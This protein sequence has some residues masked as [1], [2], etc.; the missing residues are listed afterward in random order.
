V[1][2]FDSVY[3]AL[4]SIDGSFYSES[5]FVAPVGFRASLT[6]EGK[7]RF[8][9]SINIHAIT[10]M[11]SL[12]GMKRVQV[13]IKPFMATLFFFGVFFCL[14]APL[15][16]L[17]AQEH[18]IPPASITTSLTI[19]VMCEGITDKLP[20]NPAIAFPVGNK[21]VYCLSSFDPVKEKS[22]INHFWYRKD[23]LV[24]NVRLL[25]QPPRW[26][27]YSSIDLRESDKGPW[28]V[29]VVDANNNLLK[30]LRFS[31]TD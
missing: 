4:L 30:T 12:K 17:K 25:I 10:C 19:A 23:K 2:F 9:F 11:F 20:V 1:F 3:S 16:F 14:Q 26:S 22:H 28:R 24:S 5:L 7:E 15:G 8:R 29:D 27:T 18:E 21:S 6:A 13:K 31:I